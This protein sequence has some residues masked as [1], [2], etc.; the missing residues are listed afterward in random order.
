M[1]TIRLFSVLGATL[2]GGCLLAAEPTTLTIAV[3]AADRQQVQVRL[4]AFPVGGGAEP[5]DRQVMAPSTERVDLPQGNWEVSLLS[6]AFWSAPM[7]LSAG[8]TATLDLWPAATLHGT[9][10][11]AEK[12]LKVDRLHVSFTSSAGDAATEPASGESSCVVQDEK[13]RCVVPVGQYDLRLLS[14]G[15]AA[16]FRWNVTT[17]AGAEVDLGALTLRPG[18][19]LI[20]Y[21]APGSGI[22]VDLTGVT[23][24]ARP[25][26]FASDQTRR[27][28]SSPVSARGLFQVTGLPPG[29]Y[30]IHAATKNLRSE[31]RG[32]TILA[33]RNA[34]LRSSLVIEKP[35]Q[36][37]LKVEPP[38]P[39]GERPWRIRLYR[40]IADAQRVE[41]P[42]TGSP[43]EHGGWRSDVLPGEYLLE[44]GLSE[45][46]TWASKRIVIGSADELIDLIMPMSRVSGLV[47][48]GDVPLAEARLI[49]GGEQGDHQETLRTDL[50]GRFTGEVP[51]DAKSSSM[52]TITVDAEAPRVKRT[53]RLEAAENELGDVELR[54][55][56][57]QTVVSGRVINSDGSPEP[58][59]LVTLRSPDNKVFEQTSTQ[60]DGAFELFGFEPGSYR[61]RAEAFQRSSEI[62]T[63]R[64][65]ETLTSNVDLVLQ[66]DVFVRGKVQARNT[67]G[68]GAKLTALQRGVRTDFVPNTSTDGRGLFELKLPPGTR[69]FDLIVRAPGFALAMGRVAVQ[70]DAKFLTLTVDQ[71]GGELS[72]EL[73]EDGDAIVRHDGGEFPVRWLTATADGVIVEAEDRHVA[74][75]G[76]VEAGEYTLCRADQCSGGIVTPNGS[77]LLSLKP[78]Q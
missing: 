6:S 23:V 49:F 21:V 29:E 63:V 43:D 64:A 15:F 41:D 33:D 14:R 3:H 30:V 55:E 8:E 25:R 27:S 50:Q 51:S 58:Q 57:P 45:T 56:L 13:W 11:S 44:V 66:N 7:I 73:P 9:A 1:N 37:V 72:L 52:W 26:S 53:V 4:R 62:V 74:R 61:V 59:A 65:S 28:Y 10:K 18:A 39:S 35:R 5:V 70:Q 20:G 71:N 22:R 54:I 19:S 40:L 42:I 75:L 48:L 32:V 46:S 76:K 68:V 69:V 36:L 17:R 78:V 24:T 67:A 12:G 60:A 16:E 34:E 77:L 31:E 38:R 2:L 47:T